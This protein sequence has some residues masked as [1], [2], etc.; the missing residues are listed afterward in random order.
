M[1]SPSDRQTGF[2]RPN[3]YAFGMETS[4]APIPG[5]SKSDPR[6]STGPKVAMTGSMGDG[7]FSKKSIRVAFFFFFNLISQI[8]SPLPLSRSTL[9]FPNNLRSSSRSSTSPPSPARAPSTS[10]AATTRRARA[11]T[12]MKTR[13]MPPPTTTTATAGLGLYLRPSA[14]R[15]PPP[16]PSLPWPSS[17][18]ATSPPESP[19]CVT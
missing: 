3:S 6:Q 15:A 19:L 14:S 8:F 2:F 16:A 4:R 9:R 7:R 5:S 12:T 10:A 1:T 11:T 18:S 13:A 17:G